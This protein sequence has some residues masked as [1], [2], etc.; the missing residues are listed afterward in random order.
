MDMKSIIPDIVL[1]VL[2]GIL[3]VFLRD[4][5]HR[6]IP[7]NEVLTITLFTGY[8]VQFTQNPEIKEFF[9]H[10]V[11]QKKT[12]LKEKLSGYKESIQKIRQS[13]V[14]VSNVV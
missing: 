13:R 12:T 9:F 10:K 3:A 1:L 8:L 7:F 5:D 2:I 4:M 6:N 14:G 11:T